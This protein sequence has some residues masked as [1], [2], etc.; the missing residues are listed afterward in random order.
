V[1]HEGRYKGKKP[2]SFRIGHWVC[3]VSNNTWRQ[4]IESVSDIL[5]IEHPDKFADLAMKVTGPRRNYVSTNRQTLKNGVRVHG[6]EIYIET[7][8]SANNA[9]AFAQ[10]LARAF[11]YDSV[12]VECY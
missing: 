11:G 10:E 1:N 2:Y 4:F 7:N 3:D 5:A 12:E 8:L 9:V 6:T